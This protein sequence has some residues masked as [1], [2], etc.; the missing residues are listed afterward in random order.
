MAHGDTI[1]DAIKEI[2]IALELWLKTANEM[3]IVIPMPMLYVS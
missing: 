1:E 2:Q 3:G